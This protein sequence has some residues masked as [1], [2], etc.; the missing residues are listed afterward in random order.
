MVLTM[1]CMVCYDSESKGN[2]SPDNKIKFLTSSLESCFC[3]YS[4][5]YVLVTGSIKITC[6]NNNTKVAFKNCAPF[7]DCRTEINETFIDEAEHI[8]ITMPMCN[9]IGYSDNY[10]DT[11]G[12]LWQ[13][14]RDE[15]EGNNDLTVDNSSS[16]KH[17]S[18]II[19]NLS[20]AGAKNNVKT[21]GPLKYL[22]SFWRSLEMPLINCK[23]EL[24]LGWYENCILSSAGNNATFTITDA[25]PY[26]PIVTLSAEDNAKL[27][28]LLGKGFKILFIGTN[29]R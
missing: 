1:N 5:A 22:S 20:L 24:S 14:K 8:N 16:F 17:K 6:S 23:V 27:S 3:D 2:Y 28:K 13:F 4:D 18:N 26:V 15:I 12:S 9:L 7:K 11:S 10:S 21:V 19:G 29:I 25:K